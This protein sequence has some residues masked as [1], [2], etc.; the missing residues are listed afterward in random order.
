MGVEP[1]GLDRQFQAKVFPWRNRGVL[2]PTNDAKAAALG[3]CMF[4]ASKPRVL[5]VQ[6]ACFWGVRLLGARALPG[7]KQQWTAP[8][9][10]ETWAVLVEE[11]QSCVGPF[12]AMAAYQRRQ[13]ERDGLTLLLTRTGTARAVVKVRSTGGPL[14]RE[15]VALTAVA[16]VGPATFRAPHPLGSGTLGSDLHW[17]A[18][19]S[20][21]DRPHRP[22]FDAP[23]LLFAEIQSCLTQVS[24]VGSAPAHHDLTPW[25]LRRDHH[26]VIWLYDWEDW[27]C[28]PARADEVYFRATSSALTGSPMPRGL[29][30]AAVEHW[31][32]RVAARQHSTQSDL[33]LGSR[34]LAALG[35]AAQNT[36][37]PDATTDSRL[38]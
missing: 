18:Q 14:Q 36:A 10:P 9:S 35:E 7:R 12:D 26:G 2:V 38:E 5:A 19:T 17:S 33:E 1:I 27:A 21:F 23:D 32:E 4:T 30:R 11:W 31:L 37:E 29:P 13:A 8:F 28:A 22:V 20:V 6:G 34:I 15:Q 3:I 24:D 16:A 25:N